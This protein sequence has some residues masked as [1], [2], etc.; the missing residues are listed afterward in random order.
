M[1]RVSGKENMNAI[2]TKNLRRIYKS[3][4][5]SSD[6]FDFNEN[7]DLGRYV[8]ERVLGLGEVGPRSPIG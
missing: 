7:L 6:G 3:Q 5:S 2:A 4:D 8:F 1:S